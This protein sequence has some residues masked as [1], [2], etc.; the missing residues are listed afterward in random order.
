MKLGQLP[1]VGWQAGDGNEPSYWKKSAN[2]STIFSL[3]GSP[4][5]IDTP[6]QDRGGNAIQAERHTGSSYR[7]TSEAN[8]PGASDDVVMIGVVKA[9]DLMDSGIER[10]IATR[11][12]GGTGRGV[13]IVFDDADRVGFYVFGDSAASCLSTNGSAPDNSYAIIISVC[14]RDGNSWIHLNGSSALD[15]GAT[16]SGSF[17]GDGVGLGAEPDGARLIS[18]GG[19]IQSVFV[20]YGSGIADRMTQT[21]VDHVSAGLMGIHPEQGD[22]GSFTRDSATSWRANGVWHIASSG[23][24]RAGSGID[25][26]ESGLR[27]APARTNNCY[28][29]INPQVTTGWSVTGGTNS[30]VDDSTALAAATD[31]ASAWGPNVH[32]FVPGGGDEVI[33]GG[34]TTGNTNDHSL[35]VLMRGDSGGESVDICLRDS[36]DGTITA[37]D[38][39]TL[40]TEWVRYTVSGVTPGDADEQFALD[41][42]AGDTVYFIASQ[43]EEGDVT[44][45]PIPNWATAASAARP[46]E[47][48]ATSYT[49]RDAQGSMEIGWTP[50][51]WGAVDS[52]IHTKPIAGSGSLVIYNANNGQI[53]FFDGSSLI[54]SNV[55]VVD[56]VRNHAR[57]RWAGLIKSIDVDGD[58]KTD[59]YDGTLLDTGPV[60]V[61][62]NNAESAL[63]N[64]IIYKNGSG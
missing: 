11:D 60:I 22:L 25:G 64:L 21:V 52:G 6:W 34:D 4:T 17:V 8:D 44:T 53:G 46:I 47:R 35:S 50:L 42:D 7:V 29:N 15:I 43:L 26:G 41:C 49:L 38:T 45:T 23:L 36:S 59:S 63:D 18:D 32:R 61:Q 1:D 57:A 12:S 13:Y 14:D 40:T 2:S 30:V 3:T 10:I 16:P 20:Y 58:Y 54:Q 24:P 39:V 5:L 48:L 51:G 37:G 19:S 27:A 28:N 56:G 33:Y 31:D 9:P 62:S 55:I